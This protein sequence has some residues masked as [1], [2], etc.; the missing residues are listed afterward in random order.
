MKQNKFIL[1]N[2]LGATFGALSVGCI[3]VILFVPDLYVATENLWLHGR[4][5]S[6]LGPVRL[7][8]FSGITSILTFAGFGW[9]VG[10]MYGSFIEFF[11]KRK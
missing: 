1:A 5:L 10:Y 8:F 9:I 4:N 6:I 7:E 2:A 11:S 3:L